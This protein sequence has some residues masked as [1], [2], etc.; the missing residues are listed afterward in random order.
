MRADHDRRACKGH[1]N[2]HGPKTKPWSH[3]SCK[4]GQRVSRVVKTSETAPNTATTDMQAARRNAIPLTYPLPRPLRRP[5]LLLPRPEDTLKGAAPEPPT[6]GGKGSCR[7]PEV[8]GGSLPAACMTS[9][10]KMAEVTASRVSPPSL[11]PALIHLDKCTHTLHLQG[12]HMGGG[13]EAS[14]DGVHHKQTATQ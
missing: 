3:N 12:R 5:S 1:S 10:P 9:C 4:Q 8:K 14:S 11:L 2:R 13:T 6:A 7:P